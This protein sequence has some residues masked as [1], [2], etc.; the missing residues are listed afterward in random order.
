[1][2]VDITV[3][4]A[5]LDLYWIPLGAGG[6]V[7][8]TSGRIYEGLA[9]LAQRRPRRDLYHS[10]LVAETPEGRYVVEITPVPDDDGTGRGVVGGGAVGSRLLGRFRVFRY[11][12]RRWRDGVI[13]DI[14]MPSTALSASPTTPTS[15]AAPSRVLELVPTPVWGRDQLPTRARCGTR[16]RWSPGCSNAPPS[17]TRPGCHREAVER[18]VGMRVCS[19]PD[20]RQ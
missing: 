10:A 18:Q 1:M 19:S 7:V 9:A 12:L 17:S 5:R 16:T 15:S 8:R 20:D 11:E 14:A 2:T 4:G 13:P 6:R 3:P